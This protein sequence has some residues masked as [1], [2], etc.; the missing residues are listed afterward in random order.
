MASGHDSADR[1]AHDLFE[2]F[3]TAF[4]GGDEQELAKCLTEDFEWCLPT[5]VRYQGRSAAIEVMVTRARQ[6]DG[7]KFSNSR[8]EVFGDTIVQRYNVTVGGADGRQVT[9][10]GL[11]LY[12]I[13]DGLLA[14]KD[15]YW[16]QLGAKPSV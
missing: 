5:G 2:R 9:L 15:A 6:S 13:K 14:T 16:K 11:D 10:E 1:A 8:I 7:P 12:Q 4:I 3:A